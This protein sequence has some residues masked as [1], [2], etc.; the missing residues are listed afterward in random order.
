MSTMQRRTTHRVAIA[1]RG[2]FGGPIPGSGFFVVGP[3]IAPG[4]YLT[5]GSGSFW[6]VWINGVPTEDSMCVVHLQHT[7]CEQGQRGRDEYLHRSD[8]RE[9]QLLGAGLGI[10]QLSTLDAG[11]LS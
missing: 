2:R 4:L 7:R 1:G 10:A 8:V 3:D 5:G 6:G 9:H 11:Q